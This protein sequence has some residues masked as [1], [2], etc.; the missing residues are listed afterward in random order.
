MLSVTI[1]VSF[2]LLQKRLIVIIGT[3][4]IF[5]FTEKRAVATSLVQNSVLDQFNGCFNIG[6]RTH[7]VIQRQSC[8]EIHKCF[9]QTDDRIIWFKVHDRRRSFWCH[10]SWKSHQRRCQSAH[11][12]AE[13]SHCVRVWSWIPC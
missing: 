7:V 1:N 10:Q 5:S 8:N 11:L 9:G 13:R 6:S 4:F 12:W 3:K 2:W